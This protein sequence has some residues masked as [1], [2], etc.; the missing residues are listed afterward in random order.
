MLLPNKTKPVVYND[1]SARG[2]VVMGQ[3]HAKAVLDALS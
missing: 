3:T 1:Y 2:Q